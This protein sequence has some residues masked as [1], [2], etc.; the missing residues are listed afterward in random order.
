MCVPPLTAPWLLLELFRKEGNRESE[1]QIKETYREIYFIRPE[2]LLC[3]GMEWQ[4]VLS[5][6]DGE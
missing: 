3:R 6:S 4:R 1:L 2:K 5:A